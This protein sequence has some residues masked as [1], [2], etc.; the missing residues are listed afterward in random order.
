MKLRQGVGF[1]FISSCL[2]GHFLYVPG[3]VY[4]SRN[5]RDSSPC[6]NTGLIGS[7]VKVKATSSI[8]FNGQPFREFRGVS[9]PQ[10]FRTYFLIP[11]EVEVGAKW[12]LEFLIEVGELGTPKALEVIPRVQAS[13]A[14]GYTDYKPISGLSSRHFNFLYRNYKNLLLLCCDLAVNPQLKNLDLETIK[15]YRKELI[16][17][18]AKR[19]LDPEFLTKVRAKK[20]EIQKRLFEEGAKDTS[21]EILADYF[22]ATSVKTVEAWLKK[23]ELQTVSDSKAGKKPPIKKGK[24]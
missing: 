20:K 19:K 2:A 13:R 9:L 14:S 5:S 22:D 1:H 21:N 17:R 11:D 10:S 15:E 4:S 18:T 6:I 8:I 12:S 16:A 7:E 23:E 3:L 24:K